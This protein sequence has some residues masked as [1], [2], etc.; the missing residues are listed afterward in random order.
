MVYDSTRNKIYE[1]FIGKEIS[2]TQAAFRYLRYEIEA[3][4]RTI[5]FYEFCLER[6]R[7]PMD[8]S[9]SCYLWI[10][11]DDKAEGLN[12]NEQYQEIKKAFLSEHQEDEPEFQMVNWLEESWLFKANEILGLEKKVDDMLAGNYDEE[13]AK[14][15]DTQ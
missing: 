11:S 9:C 7:H 8:T 10:G 15:S 6:R 1:D 3:L 14:D 4:D 12:K 5:D 13:L 2:S